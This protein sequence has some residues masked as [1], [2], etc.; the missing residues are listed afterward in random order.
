MTGTNPVAVRRWAWIIGTIFASMAGL[1]LAPESQPQRR[2]HHPVGRPGLRG[3]RHRVLLEPAPHLRRRAGHRHRRRLGHQVR[4]QRVSWLTGLPAGPALRHLVHRAHRD[5]AGPPGRAPGGGGPR[6]CAAAGTPRPGCAWG[7][8]RLALVFF[9][10]VPSFVGVNLS[11][12]SSALVYIMLF[13]SLGPVGQDLGAD[14]FVPP[15][16]RRRRGGGL[17]AL[18]H[19]LPH[20]LGARP[21]LGRPGRRPGR[22]PSSPSRPSGSRGCSWPSPPTASA[23]C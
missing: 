15:G 9:C 3:G 4:R 6:R 17:R 7:R 13:L 8:P 23:S 14:L 5:P 20:A 11:T 18:H 2:D 12:W 1:L 22:A 16:L 21:H 10:F 19:Q